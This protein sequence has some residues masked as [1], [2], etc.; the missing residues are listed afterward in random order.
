MHETILTVFTVTALLGLVSLLLPLAERFSI[1]YAVLLAL[2]GIAI[3]AATHIPAVYRHGGAV[4]DIIG[5]LHDFGLSA[6]SLL[7][8][9][10]PALLFEAALSCDVRQLGDEIAPVL[11]LAVIGVVVCTLVVGFALWP[12]APVGVVACIVLGAIIATTDP[13]AVVAIFRDIG[14]P[15]RLSTLVEGESL[16][17]DAA[18]IAIYSL[19]VAIL[20]G[21]RPASPWAGV[22]TFLR[23]FGGGLGVGYAAGWSVALFL[24]VLRSNRLAEA[25]LTIGFAYAVYVI[26]EHYLGVSG[27]VAVATAALAVGAEGRRR[28]APSNFDSLTITWEQL[29]FWASSLIFLLAA[30]QTPHLLA[31]ADRRDLALLGALIA[32]ALA[33]RAL[34]LYGLIPALSFARLAQPIEA[35][36]KLFMLWGGMRGAVSLALALAATENLALPPQIRQFIGVLA[37]GF[38][39]FTLLVTAPTM[40]PLMRLLRLNELP[41]AEIAL[42]ERVIGLALSSIRDEIESV[43][44][45]HEIPPEVVDEVTATYGERRR[46]TADIAEENA[47]LPAVLRTSAALRVLADREQEYCLEYFEGRTLSRRVAATLLAHTARQRDATRTH[48]IAGYQEAAARLGRFGPKYRLALSLHRRIGIAGP[49]AREI[50]DR[51]EVQVA[52]RFVLKNLAVFNRAQIGPLF[53]NGPSA[54]MARLVELRLSEIDRSIA[55]LKLQYP[56]YVRQLVSQYLARSAARLEEEGHLR[57]RAESIIN[58]DT[59]EDLQRELR[60]RRRT[61]EARTVLDLG[62]QRDELIGR[63]PM[64]AALDEATRRSVGR[65]LRPRL[66]VPGEFVVRRGE[67]GDAMYFISSGAVEV[68]I[69]P[70]PVQL[71]S[72]EFFGE[73]ALLAA[74]RRNADVVALGY[75]QLLSLA[76]RDLSRLFGTEPTL[77]EHIEDVARARSAAAVSGSQG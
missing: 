10:L 54:A 12:L 15:R 38:V 49:L 59:F 73:M 3:G 37:T 11:L 1:P 62:L 27:V 4:R 50:S 36:Y 77:R 67:R 31:R 23:Q 32:A 30:M 48:G 72:G 60:R 61:V 24:P 47:Q 25:T 58:Q 35:N 45:D 55:A 26:C 5:T 52:A 51:F 75:C 41:P 43:A 69:S 71:G 74:E 40:R 16:F 21:H 68:R 8:I 63:V 19:A 9:F 18:A 42:R 33:A 14:A 20:A 65:M 44:R 66:A 22:V 64:F 56:S 70:E 46:N 29:A 76:A 57:L 28:L 2:V 17:N 39:L 7:Y 53:G 34:T 6:E 13:V